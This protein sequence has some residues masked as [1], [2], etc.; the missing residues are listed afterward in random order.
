MA[1]SYGWPDSQIKIIDEDL[2]RSG[3]SAQQRLGW[4]SLQT[5]IEAKQVGAVFVA[6][7]SR[8]SRQVI[9][10]ELFRLRAALHNVLLYMDGQVINPADSNDTILAQTTA[11]FAQFENR[12]RAEIMRQARFAKAKKGEAVS[13]LPLGWIKGPD[14]KYD[15]DP[16]IKDVIQLVID[17][18]WATRSLYQTV[19]VLA[20]AGIRMPC[21]K[22]SRLVRPNQLC[23][24]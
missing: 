18:F 4:Q 14:G 20:K 6:N 13:Q 12:K 10:F 15:Y 11:M 22:E 5:M 17:T 19:K 23:C 16:E 3:S 24:R 7:I 21:R 8:L 2:G 9:Y 1:Q